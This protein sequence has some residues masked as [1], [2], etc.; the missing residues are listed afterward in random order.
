MFPD[1]DTQ[2][3]ER[4][5]EQQGGQWVPLADTLLQSERTGPVPIRLDGRFS[6]AV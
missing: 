4:C 3:L 5:I 1:T 6:F 2:R